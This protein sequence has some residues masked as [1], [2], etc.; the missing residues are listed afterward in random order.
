[1]PKIWAFEIPDKDPRPDDLTRGFSVIEPVS[2]YANLSLCDLV[3]KDWESRS[4][5]SD[6]KQAYAP[7]Q[8]ESHDDGN[9][10]ALGRDKEAN[11]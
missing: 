7:M 11:N 8:M 10:G 4:D 1:M 6:P 9:K 3:H 5:A 2:R